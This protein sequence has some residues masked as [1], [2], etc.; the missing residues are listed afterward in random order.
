MQPIGLK[1]AGLMEKDLR[2]DDLNVEAAGRADEY[3]TLADRKKGSP[4]AS[5]YSSPRK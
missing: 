3:Q 2:L 1:V 5:L 4:F